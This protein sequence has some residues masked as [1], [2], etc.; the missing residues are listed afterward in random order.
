MKML[1]SSVTTACIR[2]RVTGNNGIQ[3]SLTVTFA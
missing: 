1:R 2:G 3:A